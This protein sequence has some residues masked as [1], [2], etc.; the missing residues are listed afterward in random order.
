MEQHLEHRLEKLET[1]LMAAEDLLD[2]LNRTVWRQQQALELQRE[3]LR[4]LAQQV[5]TI[6]PGNPLRP[7]DEVPPHW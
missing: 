2:E 3:Q 6:Q 7:E 5:K 4:Q 1:K